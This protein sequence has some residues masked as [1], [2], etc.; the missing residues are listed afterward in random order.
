MIAAKICGLSDA[1]GVDAAVDNG[2]AFVGFVFFPPSP[3]NVTPEQAAG[4][5]R[6]VPPQ[7]VKVGLF[8]DPDDEQL[9]SV[10][11][12]ANLDLIQLHGQEEPA[13]TAAI[14]R[15]FNRPVMKALALSGPDDIKKIDAYLGIADRLLFDAPPPQGATRPG[16]NA[17]SFDWALLKGRRLGVP[18]MLAGGLTADN[19]ELAVRT[20]GAREVDVSSGVEDAPGR[21][22]P[23]KIRAFLELAGKL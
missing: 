3:R 13:R 11:H 20:S 1:Q 16:G 15:R 4:L 2:A 19:L 17:N 7:I 22:N 5:M 8:V 9:K 21:K 18:W 6:R 23:E 10:L 14:R 12:H